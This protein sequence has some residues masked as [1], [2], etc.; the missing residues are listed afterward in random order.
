MYYQKMPGQKIGRWTVLEV[1]EHGRDKHTKML[2]RCECG[3][4]K[5]VDAYSLYH[6]L[7]YSCGECNTIVDEGNYKRCI[8]KNGVSFLFDPEDEDLVKTHT[9]SLA[10]GRVRT[11]INGK[12]TYLHRMIMDCADGVQVDHINL[13]KLDNRRCNLRFASHAENQRNRRAH[14]DNASGYK[15]VCKDERTGKYFA[16]INCDKQRTYLGTFD[17]K[18]LAA[19]AYDEA[20]VR[21]HGDFACLNFERQA[22]AV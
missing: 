21:L 19:Q 10:G 16:Y 17:N 2:C 9:W 20:A 1:D 14:K 15:G 7:T 13:D 22:Q 3:K 12:N 6:H 4:I 18:H 8:M 5:S 11:L